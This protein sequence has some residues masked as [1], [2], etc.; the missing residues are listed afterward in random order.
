M[1]NHNNTQ[2]DYYWYGIDS[3][4]TDDIKEKLIQLL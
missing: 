1:K 3:I 2:D 4:I